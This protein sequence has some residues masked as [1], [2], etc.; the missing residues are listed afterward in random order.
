MAIF[1]FL[2][3]GD[4]FIVSQFFVFCKGCNE[5]KIIERIGK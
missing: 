2:F 3:D 5:S 1:S 4:G